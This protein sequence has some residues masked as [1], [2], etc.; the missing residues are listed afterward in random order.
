MSK[1][2]DSI[3]S[4]HD[5]RKLDRA[6]LHEAMAHPVRLGEEMEQLRT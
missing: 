2:L 5:L 3:D 6:K 1:L 4:P